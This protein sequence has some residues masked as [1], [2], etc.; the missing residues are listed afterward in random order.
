[1]REIDSSITSLIPTKTSKSSQA[2]ETRD[3]LYDAIYK[4]NLVE[5]LGLNSDQFNCIFHNDN[6]PSGSIFIDE[7]SGNYIYKCHSGNCEFNTDKANAGNIITVVQRLA[8]C[9]MPKAINFIK[10]V[11]DFELMETEWQIRQKEILQSNK[12]YLSSVTMKDEFPEL[13]K[14]IKN[15]IPLLLRLHDIA[16]DNVYDIP[17]SPDGKVIFFASMSYIEKLMGTNNLGKI[18][19]R[20]NLFVFLELLTKLRTDQVPADILIRAKHEAAKA[21]VKNLKSFYTIPAYDYHA[22]LRAN[23]NAILAKQHNITMKGWSREQL[24]RTFGVSVADRVF[25][26]MAGNR[27]PEKSEKFIKVFEEVLFELLKLNHYATE[28]QCL[29]LINSNKGKNQTMLKRCLQET[30]DKYNLSRVR[31]NKE[32]KE[33]YNIQSRGY[34]F[35]I[36]KAEE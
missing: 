12:N 1:M 34:P 16:T 28:N 31:C 20:I 24:I 6:N 2:F 15:Y 17:L 11:Y 21:K 29:E 23:N 10:S 13:Y 5:F 35:V 32:L 33:K 27:L 8:G 3:E 9:S 26:Q 18:N 36:V 14:K 22:L 25:P 30:L 19:N 4:I 7:E